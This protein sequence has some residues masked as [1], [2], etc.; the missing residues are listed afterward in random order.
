MCV[1]SVLNCRAIFKNKIFLILK[2]IFNYNLNK[3]FNN[4]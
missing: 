4:I 2:F 1:R 3:P